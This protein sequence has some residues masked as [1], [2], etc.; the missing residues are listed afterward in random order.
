MSIDEQK[1]IFMKKLVSP[2]WAGNCHIG[3]KCDTKQIL[4]N[5]IPSKNL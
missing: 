4:L 5:N 3:R 2:D 1:K